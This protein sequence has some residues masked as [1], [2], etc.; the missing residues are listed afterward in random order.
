MRKIKLTKPDDWHIHLR[1]GQA[2]SSVVAMTARQMGR[3]I[4]MP[5]L[6][7]PIKTAA[8]ALVYR[9]EI[10]DSL[11][12]GSDFNPLMTLYLTDKTTK[13]D[14]VDAS[15]VEDVYAVKLLSLIHI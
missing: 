9:H 15:N 13:Q 10:I 12:K 3:A 2:M 6:S 4:V 14:I 5:N 11:P 7:P 1:Q 8:Q